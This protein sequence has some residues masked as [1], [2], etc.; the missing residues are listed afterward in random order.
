MKRGLIVT[1]GNKPSPELLLREIQWADMIICADSG[2]DSMADHRDKI[3]L[4]IGDFDSTHRRE[5]LEKLDV[6]VEVLS[7]MKDETD[8]EMAFL[9]MLEYEPDEIHLLG[10]MGSRWDHSLA[11][12]L[13]LEAYLNRCKR[14]KMIDEQNE[15]QMV[16][17]GTYSV[18]KGDYHYFS[19]IPISDSVVFSTHGFKYE[20]SKL[21]I[22]RKKTRGV[23]NEII[24]QNAF[25]TLHKGTALFIK[26]KDA[27]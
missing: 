14:I 26:S 7:P 5:A 27:S 1:G 19:V 9:R 12:V 11:T 23:S 13:S 4:V 3:V 21:E 10:G 20:V 16:L 25:I 24:E 22:L 17:P 2:F 18:E 15:L 8:T 6:P